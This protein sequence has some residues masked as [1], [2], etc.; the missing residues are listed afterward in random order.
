MRGEKGERGLSGIA[1]KKTFFIRVCNNL[2]Y[3]QNSSIII[4][5]KIFIGMN[6]F[7]GRPGAPGP[8]GERGFTG[9]KGDMGLPGLQGEYFHF[10]ETFV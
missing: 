10:H 2:S 5:I 9:E 7:D 3:D 4:I 1:G 8:V 6:G